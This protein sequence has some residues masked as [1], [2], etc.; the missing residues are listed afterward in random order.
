[1]WLGLMKCGTRSAHNGG[2]TATIGEE[3][4]CTPGVEEEM[5]SL[6]K[7]EDESTL[8]QMLPVRQHEVHA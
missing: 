5:L 4:K 3:Q 7:P 1:M 2:P 6:E 8:T